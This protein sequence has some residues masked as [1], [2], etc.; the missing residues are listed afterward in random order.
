MTV[1]M[2]AIAPLVMYR[3]WPLRMKPLPSGD[4]VAVV[5]T[6]AASEPAS[7]SVSA[8]APSLR[9]LTRSGSHFACCSLVPNRSS[10][11]MPIEWWALTK[12][13]VELH[14]EPITSSSRQ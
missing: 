3:F 10:A 14:R 13:A 7:G 5:C 12:I 4:G 6:L 2:P 8:N 9:P 1:R 11:R